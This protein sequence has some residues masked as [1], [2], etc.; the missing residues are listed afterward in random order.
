MKKLLF[1]LSIL[2]TI[3]IC[4]SCD[5]SVEPEWFTPEPVN[6]SAVDTVYHINH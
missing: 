6:I 3:L 5:N 1:I 2:V 4:T